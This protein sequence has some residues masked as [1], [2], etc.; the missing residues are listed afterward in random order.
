[1]KPDNTTQ[2]WMYE[3]MV[4]SRYLEECLATV[5]MEGKKPIFDLAKGPIPGEM[6]LSRGQEPAAVGVCAHLRVAD[7]LTAGHRLH[8]F[9]IAKGVRLRPMVAEIFGKAS[10]LSG[11]RG[12]HMHIIDATCNFSASGIVCEG[13]APAAGA[14]LAFQLRGEPNVGVAVIGEGAANAGVFHETLNLAALWRLPFICLIEDNAWAVTVSKET[15]TA[16]PRNDVRAAAYG[17][18][19]AYV[20]GNDPYEI[21]RVVGEAIE[22]ARAGG[23]PTLVE[24]ETWRYDGHFQ[25]DP[26]AYRPK[27]EREAL[28]ARDPI[29]AM[30]ARMLADK[31]AT[32]GALT[33]LEAAAKGAV[34][35]AIQFARDSE[36]AAGEAALLHVYA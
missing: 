21:Y 36:L 8:H 23:G 12:G 30:R 20:A 31:V 35:E 32:E 16:V 22:R 33:R 3:T 11:G 27:G 2:L 10:G 5:Y 14:A 19:G 29:P 28:L 17:I 9:A 18:P 25:G 6:H 34:D 7:A 4:K 26:A 13:M 15:S 24:V 1:M